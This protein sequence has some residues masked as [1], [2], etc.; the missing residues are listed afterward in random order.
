MC[1]SSA[2]WLAALRSARGTAA[3]PTRDSTRLAERDSC[4]SFAT[5]ATSARAPGR[6]GSDSVQS[7]SVRA[8]RPVE[9]DSLAALARHLRRQSETLKTGSPMSS[10]R[11]VSECATAAMRSEDTR[12]NSSHEWISYAVFCLKKK[13]KKR[14]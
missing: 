10:M 1:S 12:L 2:P 6:G 13:K 9:L 11:G 7:D 8:A 3:H 14:A 4:A 5:I